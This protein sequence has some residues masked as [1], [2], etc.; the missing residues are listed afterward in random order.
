M[1]T[2]HID[3][4]ALRNNLG[5]LRSRLAPECRLLAAVKANGYGHGACE[6]ARSL[7]ESGVEWF[8]VATPQEALELRRSGL[9]GNILLFGPTSGEVAELVDAGVS[10]TVPGVEALEALSRADLPARARVHLKVDTGMG[11]LGYGPEGALELAREID[12]VKKVEL[13]GVYSHF[14]R[15]DEADRTFT[16]HQ[17]SLFEELLASLQRE[18]IRPGI[19]HACNSAGLLT[20][21]AAHYDMVR[22][23]IS[24]YGYS[25]GNALPEPGLT[26]VMT[27]TAP[28]TFVKRVREGTPV[29]YGGTWRAPRETTVATIRFGYADG[30]PRLLGNRGWAMLNGKRVAVAGRV[31]MDQ[32][33][34]DV[35]DLEVSPG[36]RATLFGPEGPTAAEIGSLIDTISYEMLTSVASRVE[37]VYSN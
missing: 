29:S 34:L 23:G 11:R 30:Y 5:L 32:L 27:L 14:A 16:A 4:A 19:A 9:S 12:R 10:L 25:P 2:A 33:M 3:L 31:C 21:P 26:P 8:G 6:V 22:P 20:Y 28:V 7:E 17:I 15:A 1:P 13:E 35:G 24:L 18:G 36:D 37:R